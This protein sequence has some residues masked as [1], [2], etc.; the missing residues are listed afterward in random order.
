MAMQPGNCCTLSL[1]GSPASCK[2]GV[3]GGGVWGGGFYGLLALLHSTIT[4]SCHMPVTLTLSV[5][6]A[7]ALPSS[8]VHELRFGVALA[9]ACQWVL[10]VMLV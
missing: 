5:H 8:G 9:S 1:V 6:W 10:L 7:L 3:F 2:D 4:W